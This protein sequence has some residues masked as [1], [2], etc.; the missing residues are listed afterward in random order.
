[1]FARADIDAAIKA[2]IL[3]R[4]RE[5]GFKGSLPHL[6]RLRNGACDY[7]TFQ[8]RSAGGAFVVELAR[9]SESG[10]SFHG[11]HIPVAK[12]NTT[13]LH[14]RHRLGS[15]L[16]GGDHWYRFDSVAPE[17]VAERVLGDLDDPSVWQLIDSFPLPGATS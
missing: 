15:P 12:V 2:L 17:A 14:H 16:S 8:F 13:Y 1:M 6:H 4:L 11:R 5:M 10:L 7:L 3:P 9:G